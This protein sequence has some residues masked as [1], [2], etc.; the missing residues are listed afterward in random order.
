MLP[1]E[2]SVIAVSLAVV[3]VTLLLVCW[4]CY[5]QYVARSKRVNDSVAGVGSDGGRG[6]QGTMAME[7]FNVHKQEGLQV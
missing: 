1:I 3:V 4:F 5:R 7:T 6:G 2:A